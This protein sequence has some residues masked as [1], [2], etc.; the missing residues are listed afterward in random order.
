MTRGDLT[1]L[2]DRVNAAIDDRIDEASADVTVRCRDGREHHVFVEHAVGS[3]RRPMSDDDLAG[4]F[5]RLVDPI[6]GARRAD[7]LIVNSMR[8]AS[9]GGVRALAALARPAGIA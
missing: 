4:K 2:R 3:L 9:A 1:A 5:H 6:L 7:D 8:I